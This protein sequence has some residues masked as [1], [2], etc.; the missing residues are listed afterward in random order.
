MGQQL[1]LLIGCASDF[2]ISPVAEAP[3]SAV[4][5][6]PAQLSS[7]RS[8]V[9]RLELT[10]SAELVSARECGPATLPDFC[11]ERHINSDGSFCLGW[12]SSAAPSVADIDSANLWW[13]GLLQF[14]RGQLRAER[15]RRWTAGA[16]WAHGHAAT[17]QAMAEAAAEQFGSRFLAALAAGTVTV[18]RS[19]VSL[20]GRGR[21]LHVRL[22]GSHIYSVW[23]DR[24]VVTNSRRACIC[25]KGSIRRHR[26]LRDCGSH[27]EAA[28][29]L[30]HALHEW[31]RA[32]AQ[33]WDALKGQ[34]CCGTM[35]DCPLAT[36]PESKVR[37]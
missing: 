36:S 32:E 33:F 6:V 35:D 8:R 26:R 22:D 14:L 12:A 4:L 17:H 28:A 21:A 34:K 19:K 30:A 27:A 2:G 3:D 15:A 23:E 18:T 10:E 13:G 7:G 1:A 20:P 5:D 29:D 9:F 16:T 31:K 37:L 24:K 25:E 11:P